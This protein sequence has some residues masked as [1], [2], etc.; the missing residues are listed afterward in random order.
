MHQGES[1]HTINVYHTVHKMVRYTIE[2]GEQECS[3]WSTREKPSNKSNHQGQHTWE[4]DLSK[5]KKHM[6]EKATWTLGR[7][8]IPEEEKK[9]KVET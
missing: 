4:D 1:I 2:T 5:D 9:W 3:V 6:D 8:R 7:A